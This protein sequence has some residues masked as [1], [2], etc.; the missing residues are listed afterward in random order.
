MLVMQTLNRCV[1]TDYQCRCLHHLFRIDQADSCS[2]DQLM[3]V[4]YTSETLQ[5]NSLDVSGRFQ[6]SS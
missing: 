1:S 6:V 4:I 3:T 5:V 2:G